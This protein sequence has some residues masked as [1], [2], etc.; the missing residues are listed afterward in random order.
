MMLP[1]LE[2]GPHHP[3]DAGGLRSTPAGTAAG[4]SAPTREPGTASESGTPSESES[5]GSAKAG[6]AKARAGETSGGGRGRGR[7]RLI[8]IGQ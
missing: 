1:R 3:S 6:A 4:E 5:A 2:G 8:E 7:Y